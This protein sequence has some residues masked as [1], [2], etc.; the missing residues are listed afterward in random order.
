[1]YSSY[2]CITNTVD[3]GFAVSNDIKNVISYCIGASV[4]YLFYA[5]SMWLIG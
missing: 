1:M 2:I 5:I 3:Q 4:P